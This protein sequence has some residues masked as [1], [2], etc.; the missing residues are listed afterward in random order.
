MSGIL[1]RM[2]GCV[3]GCLVGNIRERAVFHPDDAVGEFSEAAIVGDDDDGTIFLVS[4][5]GHHGDYCLA[6]V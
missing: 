4:E 1:G 5:A 2:K 6:G 3:I